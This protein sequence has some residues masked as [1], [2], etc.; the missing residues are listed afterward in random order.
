MLQI[1][2]NKKMMVKMM[3]KENQEKMMMKNKNQQKMMKLNKESN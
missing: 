1:D 2:H 3:K